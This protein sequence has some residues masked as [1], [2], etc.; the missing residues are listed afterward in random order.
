LKVHTY[1]ESLAMMSYDA[2]SIDPL[3][4]YSEPD[5]LNDTI[6]AISVPLVSINVKDKNSG[7]PI[8]Q[9]FM[10]R[11][12]GGVRVA[13]TA[14][15]S[16]EEFE[17]SRARPDKTD[18]G[19]HVVDRLEG[20]PDNK[21]EQLV[22]V[23]DQS[24]ALEKY[25]PDMRDNS[26][27]VILITPFSHA[28]NL[29]IARRFPGIGVILGM[30]ADVGDVLRDDTLIVNNRSFEGRTLGKLNLTLDGDKQILR[31]NVEWLPVK[32]TYVQNRDIRKLLNEFYKTVSEDPTLWHLV[33][34]KLA[35]FDLEKD[36]SNEYVGASKCIV[37][38]EQIY[39]SWQKSRLAGAY[40]SLVE[41]DKS[42]FPECVSCHTTGSGFPS[43]FRIG[44]E[45]R[46]LEGV[47]CEVCHGPAS[48]HLASEGKFSLRR[49]SS[50]YF[51]MECHTSDVSPNFEDRFSELRAKVDHRDI[52]RHL[53]TA[54]KSN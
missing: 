4:L 49:P 21:L 45:R 31:Y 13:L 54:A 6:S 28:K 27:L 14:F 25:L 48:K 10:I 18:H 53:R 11:E 24:M 39:R 29:V 17:E 38:H 19:G 47:Q 52:P 30:N 35:S 8:A 41:E 32:V 20:S 12:C 22:K 23:E 51:C 15:V 36:E 34:R 40:T 26:D 2:I 16:P 9:P 46:H 7:R 44:Q 1:L 33:E 5:F 43:G 42:F 50:H 37:C 3:F